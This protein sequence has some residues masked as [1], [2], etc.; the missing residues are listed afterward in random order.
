[1]AFGDV[2]GK[3]RNK[4]QYYSILLSLGI[5]EA[6]LHQGEDRLYT[7]MTETVLRED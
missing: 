6:P 5:H 4:H 2:G 7:A 3:P 1:M